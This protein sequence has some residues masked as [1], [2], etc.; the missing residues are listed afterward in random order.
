MKII[1]S[2]YRTFF[3]K[4]IRNA[5]SLQKSLSG[6]SFLTCWIAELPV[7]VTVDF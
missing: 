5:D 4:N 1:Q 6:V 2:K 3:K 7:Y